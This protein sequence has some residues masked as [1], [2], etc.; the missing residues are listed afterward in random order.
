MMTPAVL[1]PARRRPRFNHH[2]MNQEDTLSQNLRL[3]AINGTRY[4]PGA[5]AVSGMLGRVSWPLLLVS[6]IALVAVSTVAIVVGRRGLMPAPTALVT[7]ACKGLPV[8]FQL[9]FRHG[10]DVVQLRANAVTLKGALLNGQIRWAD[11]SGASTPL[12]F[13]PPT[14]ILYDDTKSVRVRDGNGT[15]Q[16]CDR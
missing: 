2:T 1:P 16:L 4:G 5:R 7:Y 15:E 8:P 11:V 10:M 3:S 13:A 14:E 12:G 9:A 6:G